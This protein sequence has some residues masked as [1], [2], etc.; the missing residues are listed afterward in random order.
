MSHMLGQIALLPYNFAPVG[1]MF[2]EGQL[3]SIAQ[4]EA[5][6]SVVGNRFGGDNE[7]TFALPDLR[8][9]APSNCHY[10]MAVQG[11]YKPSTYEA[12]LGE[13][14]ISFDAPTAQN[15]LEC[16]GQS[17]GKNKYPM[18]DA[19]LGTRFGGSGGNFNLPDLRG[20]APA[21]YRYVM[22]VT[23][24]DPTSPRERDT[25]IGELF[26]LP[27]EVNT[28]RFLPCDGRT[29]PVNKHQA[30]FSLIGN[31]FGGD[32]QMTN[33]SLPDMRSMAPEKFK[34]YIADAGGY[35]PRRQ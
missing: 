31:M 21:G 26:L 10:S 33:F 27:Y 16:T 29:L 15:V 1:W 35:Y 5:L 17:L 9:A 13:T 18:L 23:G 8:K 19:Y 32:S 6:Y 24:D 7:S 22:G 4:Y 25:M 30:L 12:I 2:C 14:S 28:E 3:L 20:K 34:Y 11:Y